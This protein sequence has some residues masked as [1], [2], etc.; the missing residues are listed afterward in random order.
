MGEDRAEATSCFESEDI[1]GSLSSCA[2][3]ASPACV[4]VDEASTT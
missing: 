4:E 3:E 1:G 2:V